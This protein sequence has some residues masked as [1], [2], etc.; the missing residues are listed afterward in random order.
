MSFGDAREG[1][2]SVGTSHARA[3]VYAWLCRGWIVCL[4]LSF[5]SLFHLLSILESPLTCSSAPLD[6][7]RTQQSKSTHW[8]RATHYTL[9]D[10]AAGDQYRSTAATAFTAPSGVRQT[11]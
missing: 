4:F 1:G 11:E 10:A 5:V 8:L 6:A 2:T 9:G 3:F 7:E